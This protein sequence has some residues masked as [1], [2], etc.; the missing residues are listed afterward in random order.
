MTINR[1][2]IAAMT[3][4]GFNLLGTIVT[5]V[6][7]LQKSKNGTAD[8]I[9]QGTQFTGPLVF[10]AIAIIALGFTYTGRKRLGLIG[11]FLIGLWGAG[12]SVGEI[13]EFFQKRVGIS[14]GKWDVVLAGSAIGLVVGITTAVTAVHLVLS[15]RQ[16]AVA[17]V[18]D[19]RINQVPQTRRISSQHE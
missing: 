17:T 4:I 19:K 10:V 1:F 8:A 15:R 5:W 12:F 6:F 16:L 18:F 13:S 7:H 2:R 3:I 11:V 9:A 14:P